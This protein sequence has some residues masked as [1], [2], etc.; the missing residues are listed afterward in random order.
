MK[1]VL[2][3]YSLGD[4]IKIEKIKSGIINST[5]IIDTSE[6]KFI[7]QEIK[8]KDMTNDHALVK[9]YIENSFPNSDLKV[10]NQLPAKNGEFHVEKNGKIFRIMDY[11]ENQELERIT[12]KICYNLGESLAKFHLQTS[13]FNESLKYSIP[14]FHNTHAIIDR[15]KEIKVE[16]GSTKKW[17]FVSEY[18]NKI[19]EDIEDF[20]LPDLNSRLIHGDP[21]WQNFLYDSGEVTAIVDLETL[22]YGNELIDIG[23]ALRSWSKDKDYNFIKE[24]FKF[25]IEGY[26]SNNKNVQKELIPKATALI[27]LE[28][29]ARFLIDY[30]EQTYFRNRKT[31]WDSE[32]N[33]R[34][35]KNQMKFYS[36]M[37]SQL[38]L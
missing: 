37:K 31:D 15:L 21:K 33:F 12:P 7:L 26:I 24:N 25:A 3:E 20:Y 6:G 5:F 38:K 27:T 10:P 13:E 19:I 36:D 11:I 34:R 4:L 30:F 23:D 2:N 8:N 18:Y 1:E 16:Y 17:K 22:M 32:E 14:N 29:S 28:L 9:N 35:L